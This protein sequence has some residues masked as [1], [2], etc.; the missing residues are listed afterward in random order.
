MSE[1]KM[2]GEIDVKI[3]QAKARRD[4]ERDN[5]KNEWP[6]QEYQ[7]LED[8]SERGIEGYVYIP[9]GADF[10]IRGTVRYWRSAECIKH[11]KYK[12]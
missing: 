11:A 4:R 7:K 9:Y 2:I 1:S 8:G 3:R 10:E 12:G 6:W 5:K